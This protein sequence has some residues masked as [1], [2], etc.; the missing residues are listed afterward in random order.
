MTSELGPV[1]AVD[2]WFASPSDLPDV[3]A[4]IADHINTIE[5]RNANWNRFNGELKKHVQF[6]KIVI[7]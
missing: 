3:L 4:D 6:L 2:A 5:R 7:V 1:I